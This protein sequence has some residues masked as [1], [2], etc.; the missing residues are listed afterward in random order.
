MIECICLTDYNDHVYPQIYNT[1]M[2]VGR[3]DHKCCECDEIIPKGTEHEIAKGLFE[4]AW[5]EYRTCRVCLSVRNHLFK[6]GWNHS[7]M[8]EDIRE[9][10]RM[11]LPAG[12]QDDFEWLK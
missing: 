8:W 6:C 5:F 4:G 3:K 11:Q 1:R 9:M 10:M 2:I 7:C 12:E